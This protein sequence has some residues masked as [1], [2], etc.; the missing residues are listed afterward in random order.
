MAIYSIIISNWLTKQQILFSQ[1][2]SNLI[3]FSNFTILINI[4]THLK[5]L[6]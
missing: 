4:E 3:K 6:K 1:T 2:F 5:F